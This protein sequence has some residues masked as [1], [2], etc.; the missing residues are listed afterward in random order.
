M[1]SFL[2]GVGDEA[3][4][5]SSKRVLYTPTL[6]AKSSLLYLQEIGNL[7]AEQPHT[8]SRKHLPSYLFFCVNYGNGELKYQGKIH[9]LVQGD[10]VFIDCQLPY[11][12]STGIVLWSLSWIHFSGVTMKDIY[13]KYQERGGRPIFHPENIIPFIELHKNLL[14]LA[15]SD[16]HIRDMRIN[17]CLNELLILLMNESWYPAKKND[18]ILKKQNIDPIREFLDA[19]YTEKISLDTL[20]EQFFISKFYLTR[21]FK[22]QFGVSINTYVL[23]LRITKAKQ[24]LRFTDKKLEDIGYQC[25]LGAPHYFSRIF[26]QIEGITPSEFREKW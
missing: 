8:S 2:Y 7:Q 25:G 15:T 19:H 12:H 11:S 5:V 26:K 21:V 24:M 9:K 4:T 3:Q 16:D 14:D 17:S 13:K 10:C 20:A 6:F 22:E 18:S 23:N 1:D